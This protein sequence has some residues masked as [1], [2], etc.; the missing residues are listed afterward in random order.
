VNYRAAIFLFGEPSCIV[1]MLLQ[2]SG[3][4]LLLTELDQIRQE[5][6]NIII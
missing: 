5:I 1:Q 2:S 6:G 4:D 3:V